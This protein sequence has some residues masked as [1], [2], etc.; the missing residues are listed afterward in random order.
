MK[1]VKEAQNAKFLDKM[2]CL[3]KLVILR[4]LDYVYNLR[5]YCMRK[6]LTQLCLGKF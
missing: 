5:S 3:R 6:L 1:I 4:T 2:V